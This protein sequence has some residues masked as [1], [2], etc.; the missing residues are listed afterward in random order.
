MPLT[1]FAGTASARANALMLSPSG[2]YVPSWSFVVIHAGLG[3]WDNAF[4]WFERAIDEHEPLMLHFH[5]HPNYGPL[6]AHPRFPAQMRK[7]NLEP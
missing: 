2:R 7:M 5:V 4:D 6:H 3:E 1:R